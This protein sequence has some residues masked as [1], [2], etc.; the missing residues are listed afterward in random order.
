MSN[1]TETEPAAGSTPSDPPAGETSAA[2]Q[3]DACLIRTFARFDTLLVAGVCV[4]VPTSDWYVLPLL[5][6]LHAAYQAMVPG[7]LP[8]ELEAGI[9]TA[10]PVPRRTLFRH[11]NKPD[12]AALSYPFWTIIKIPKTFDG[13][14]DTPDKRAQL[15]HE[16]GHC[17]QYD[18]YALMLVSVT[19]STNLL[20]GGIGLLAALAIIAMPGAIAYLEALPD[21]PA[22]PEANLEIVVLYGV[23]AF[24]AAATL[25]ERVRFIHRRELNADRFAAAVNPPAYLAFLQKRRLRE[26]YSRAAT[27]K[28]EGLNEAF[29][30]SF[31]VRHAILAEGG[32][33]DRR[34]VFRDAAVSSGLFVFY[35]AVAS[36]FS[37]SDS[38][39]IAVTLLFAAFGFAIIAA[40]VR[41]IVQGLSRQDAGPYV[42]AFAAG[43]VLGFSGTFVA[44]YAVLTVIGSLSH[45]NF[46]QFLAVTPAA[47]P[48]W[49]LI[50]ITGCKPLFAGSMSNTAFAIWGGLVFAVCWVLAAYLYEIVSLRD[51]NPGPIALCLL[52]IGLALAAARLADHA[53]RRIRRT[54]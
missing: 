5:L 54:L 15:L 14:D 32:T 1:R 51:F 29:H 31:A 45:A 9:R 48:L 16:L 34:T 44:I 11:H 41:Q 3:R 18:W 8:R 53:V 20:I 39:R 28:T 21:F 2:I 50:C 35:L 26:R 19:A 40:S 17:H 13:W 38:L 27:K 30:P 52:A 33:I 46:W 42:R 37:V 7:R 25:I 47:Y 10:L 22:F 6:M 24:V 43:S 23:W 36:L 4:A 49:M 12:C